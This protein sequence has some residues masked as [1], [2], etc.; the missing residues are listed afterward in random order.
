M[1]Q[2]EERQ[3]ESRRG[4]VRHDQTL[5][6]CVRQ[7]KTL[8]KSRN[9]ERIRRVSAPRGLESPGNRSCHW[10]LELPSDTLKRRGATVKLLHCT[11]AV[12]WRGCGWSCLAPSRDFDGGRFWC[13][14]ARQTVVRLTFATW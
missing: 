12:V 2:F 8:Y 9:R 10:P 11:I 14:A 13:T 3:E 1:V 7:V 4:E 6:H 5:K